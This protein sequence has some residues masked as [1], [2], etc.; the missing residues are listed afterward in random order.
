MPPMTDPLHSSPV[1]DTRRR[2][3][4]VSPLALLAALL[5][6]AVAVGMFWQMQQSIRQLELQV[7]RR[8]GESDMSSKEAS[9][10]TKEVR[11]TV[12]DLST[13]VAALEAQT[14]QEREQQLALQSMYQALARSQDER[15]L[16]DIGQTL[17]LANQQLEMAGNVRAAVLGLEPVAEEFTAAHRRAL[18]PVA[19]DRSRVLAAAL[20]RIGDDQ[21]TAIVLYDI[22]GYDYTEIASL[23]GVSLGTVKSRIHRGR[24]A[25]RAILADRLELLRDA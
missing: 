12:D 11:A 9:S 7:A 4:W 2:H 21:R 25:L 15:E 23:T 17:M 6:I 22:E 14:Q 16:A 3:D 19:A 5:A 8:I 18:T 1:H 13:R 10:A 20:A 24:L